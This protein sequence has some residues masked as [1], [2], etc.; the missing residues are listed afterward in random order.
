MNSNYEMTLKNTVQF[1]M[2]MARLLSNISPKS[3]L[4]VELRFGMPRVW[5]VAAACAWS[6]EASSPFWQD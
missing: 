1:L 2:D 5:S 4:E 3:S 6:F